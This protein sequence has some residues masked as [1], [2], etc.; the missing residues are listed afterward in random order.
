[1]GWEAGGH[2]T[3]L[4]GHQP[5]VDH[6]LLGQ[7]VCERDDRDRQWSAIECVD[8]ETRERGRER[9]PVETDSLPPG[10]CRTDKSAPIVALYWFENFLLT[11]WFMRDVFPTLRG[12]TPH[13]RQTTSDVEGPVG[14]GAAD[15]GFDTPG[16]ARGPR[17]ADSVR[18]EQ[19]HVS[20]RLQF[21][22]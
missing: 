22:G 21:W 3:Y 19:E 8:T 15:E 10:G 1:M 6:N 4:H 5:V 11:Y 13:K 16:R 20:E 12:W 18:E 7:A 2:E 9:G 17:I 14:R